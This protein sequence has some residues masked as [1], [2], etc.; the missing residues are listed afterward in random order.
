M[1]WHYFEN[2]DFKNKNCC[3]YFL[4]TLKTLGCFLIQ[5]LITQS[6]PILASF[7]SPGVLD[8]C[9]DYFFVFKEL[10]TRDKPSHLCSRHRH[11]DNNNIIITMKS[12]I[13]L[14]AFIALASAALAVPMQG[15]N[16]DITDLTEDCGKRND[17][18]LILYRNLL[19]KIML[20]LFKAFQLGGNLK[21][22][23][24]KLTLFL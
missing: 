5:N 12:F 20:P 15:S 6:G 7:H 21:L 19:H 8:S 10:V 18:R 23:R 17:L 11:D 13:T 3:G 14:A 22:A 16:G 9:F 24:H 1:F 4:K 2:A